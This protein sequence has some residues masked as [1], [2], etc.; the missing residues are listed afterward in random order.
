LSWRG[1]IEEESYITGYQLCHKLPTNRVSCL[2]VGNVT[3]VVVTAPMS[4]CSC[5]A[6]A[7]GTDDSEYAYFEHSVA[8]VT[9]LGTM[10]F[11][12][13]ASNAVGL[14]GKSRPLTIRV[15]TE[16]PNAPRISF[17][18]LSR[19]SSV[20]RTGACAP[21]GNA[22]LLHPAGMPSELSWATHFLP[23]TV[24]LLLCTSYCVLTGMPLEL[25]WA[26]EEKEDLNSDVEV[27]PLYEMCLDSVC[28]NFTS[29][30]T[31][32]G[33]HNFSVRKVSVAGLWSPPTT[34]LLMADKS[35]PVMGDVRPFGPEPAPL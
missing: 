14:T 34:W 5:A 30:R 12:L 32:P 16:P 6:P 15:N 11:A 24:C 17:V 29:G 3:R 18:G 10:L 27:L 2:D 7:D 33:L 1:W 31:T 21:S 28:A 35:P 19:M 8:N 9:S 25:L 20:N 26:P 22:T 23:L 13:H 4:S